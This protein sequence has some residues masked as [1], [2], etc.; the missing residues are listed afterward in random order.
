MNVLFVGHDV[1]YVN[2]YLAIESALRQ[3]TELSS[4][5]LYSRPSAWLYSRLLLGLQSRSPSLS[6]LLGRWLTYKSSNNELIDL[7]FYPSSSDVNQR[8]RF[9]QIYKGYFSFIKKTL[10]GSD[11]DLAILPGEYRL[12][13]QATIA[14]LESLKRTPQIIYF[15][16]GPPGYVYLDKCGVNANASFATT[17][18]SDLIENIASQIIVPTI[19]RV[20]ISP[21]T[22]KC[23]LVFDMAWLWLTKIT[24]GL[25]DLEEFWVAMKNRLR[26]HRLMPKKVKDES[27]NLLISSSI[28]FIGQVRNDINNT[29]FGITDVELEQH[30]I[31]LLSSD[32]SIRMIW[33]DHPLE[34][35]DK[36]FQRLSDV[37]PGRV[38]RL[39]KVQ[40][41]RLLA[42]VEG[43]VTV[44]SNA[45]LEALA[46]GL[47]VRLLGRSYFAIL[48]GVCVDN[49]SFEI[50]RKKIKE[51]GPDQAIRRDAERFLRECFLPIDYRGGDFSNA[52]LAAEV[53]LSCKI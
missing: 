36:L 33:R 12:F 8:V 51:C 16:A 52:H 5:H 15:E 45:G 38:F 37:F 26:I 31:E 43:V 28:I 49:F 2:F 40:L 4:L 50:F 3:R 44:N 27:D 42:S 19:T 13:E 21:L 18:V 24:S 35:S 22:R 1:A 41:Q 6:R 32:L 20:T 53:I 14:V 48:Q 47:P 17:G 10:S 9:E 11:F 29:H 46:S 39:D 23:L 7:R 30:L 25:L 34:F